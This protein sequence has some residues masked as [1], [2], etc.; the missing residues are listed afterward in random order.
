MT[1]RAP[2]WAYELGSVSSFWGHTPT[3]AARSSSSSGLIRVTTSVGPQWRD[4]A[5]SRLVPAVLRVLT[6]TKRWRCEAI[7][8]SRLV[9][10]VGQLLAVRAGSRRPRQL[11]GRADD[12]QLV[13][14]GQQRDHGVEVAVD[15][16]VAHDR[17]DLV[18][19]PL[20]LLAH[21]GDQQ[22]AL[23][24]LESL[25]VGHQVLHHRAEHRRHRRQPSRRPTAS[26]EVITEL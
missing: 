8:G 9:V 16:L 12:D 13:A 24:D 5:I 7:T 20:R 19:Q 23:G 2:M 1:R 6:K 21:L 3:A 25:A 26:E 10:L 22:L 14:A 17:D 15:L 18:G 4:S 11:L